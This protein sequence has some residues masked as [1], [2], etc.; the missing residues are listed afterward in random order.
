MI[1][2]FQTRRYESQERCQSSTTGALA[3]HSETTV[4]S[5]DREDDWAHAVW[6]LKSGGMPVGYRHASG[7]P[8][9]AP[10]PAWPSTHCTVGTTSGTCGVQPMCV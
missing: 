8:H 5:V 9:G 1:K 6:V 4:Q 7:V 2:P 10:E 3:H